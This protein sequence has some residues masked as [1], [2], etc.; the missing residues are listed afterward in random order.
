MTAVEGTERAMEGGGSPPTCCP[1]APGPGPS[2]MSVIPRRSPQA[3]PKKGATPTILRNRD[4]HRLLA[5]NITVKKTNF[6]ITQHG[7]EF[8][9]D[10][11]IASE[12]DFFVGCVPLPPCHRVTRYLPHP[13]PERAGGWEAEARRPGKGGGMASVPS[14]PPC[15]R[16]TRRCLDSP[17]PCVQTPILLLLCRLELS[18][19]CPLASAAR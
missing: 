2:A 16:A 10:C 7:V 18:G 4:H 5:R 13:P 1:S 8:L 12:A 9:A 11:L 19:A 3:R 6:S 17:V 15:E 14:R